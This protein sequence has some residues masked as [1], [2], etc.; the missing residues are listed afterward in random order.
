[1]GF[2]LKFELKTVIAL[3][4]KDTQEIKG[5]LKQRTLKELLIFRSLQ[6]CVNDRIGLLDLV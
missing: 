4:S 2:S 6:I 5:T 3:N 1:M